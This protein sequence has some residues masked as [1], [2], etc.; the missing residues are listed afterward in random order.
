MR[1]ASLVV[2]HRWK[3]GCV[4]Q[5]FTISIAAARDALRGNFHL[6]TC[7]REL[8]ITMRELEPAFPGCGHGTGLHRLEGESAYRFLLSVCTGLESA[9]PGETDI[10]GQYKEA[11]KQFDA[12]P[13]SHPISRRLHPAL[14]R[15]TQKIFEDT[16]DIRSKYLQ[17]IGG[18]SYGSLVRKLIRGAVDNGAPEGPIL[19]IGAGQMAYAVAPYLTDSELWL[20]NRSSQKLG[21]LKEHLETRPSKSRKGGN[22]A[23]GTQEGAQAPERR[24]L[25]IKFIES[26]EEGWKSAA[27]VVICIPRSP[28]YDPA[29]IELRHAHEL[30]SKAKGIVVHLGARESESQD[31]NRLEGYRSLDRLF[32]LQGRQDESRA[33]LIDLAREACVE[34]ASMRAA[35]SEDRAL[36]QEKTAKTGAKVAAFV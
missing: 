20:W 15:W 33:R 9:I 30:A 35:A 2:F 34:K 11:W 13:T 27:H 32:E 23:S 12:N 18:A 1:L 8:W 4:D 22:A 10:F 17:G 28:E 5:T 26:E 36:A 21:A 29:R 19:L 16:K 24:E 25:N 7:Q 6:D 14:R 31:W 3:Q